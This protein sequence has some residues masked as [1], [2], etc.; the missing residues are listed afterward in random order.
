MMSTDAEKALNKIEQ[1]FVIKTLSDKRIE[2]HVLKLGREL[3]L[4]KL[5][6]K[7]KKPHTKLTFVTNDII[8]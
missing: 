5:E 7:E 8:I 2:W 6:R 4:Y 3:T 1:S